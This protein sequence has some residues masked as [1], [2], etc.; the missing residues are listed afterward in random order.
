M[1]LFD[2]QSTI[3]SDKILLNTKVEKIVW[4]QE[5]SDTNNKGKTNFLIYEK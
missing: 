5:T 2:F 4:K 3:G 1:E